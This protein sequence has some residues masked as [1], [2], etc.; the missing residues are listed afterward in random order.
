MAY[1]TKYTAT[2]HVNTNK[3]TFDI[4]LDRKFYV[5][6]NLCT[7]IQ[8]RPR[9]RQCCDQNIPNIRRLH[10][11]YGTVSS[12]QPR[13]LKATYFMNTISRIT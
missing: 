5:V 10:K 1:D 6:A 7:W 2:D 8:W 4:Q 11:K 12:A 9:V 3:D 13:H